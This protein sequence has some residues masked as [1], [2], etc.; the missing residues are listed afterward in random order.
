M[1][2]RALSGHVGSLQRAVVVALA[3][4]AMLWTTACL[5]E[6]DAPPPT[7][8]PT[9][10][11]D[12]TL[13]PIDIGGPSGVDHELAEFTGPM[14]DGTELT[15]R[16]DDPSVRFVDGEPAEIRRITDLAVDG[17][18]EQ[19][20]ATLEFWLGYAADP[21]FDRDSGDDPNGGDVSDDGTGQQA[22]LFGRAA[23]D[24][25]VFVGCP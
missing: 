1:P 7:A 19:L 23:Y 6:V 10:A 14:L 4:S 3:G 21:E 20:H 18:C 24:A 22:S 15:L 2:V 9:V 12:T 17:E 25:I 13:V 5:P 8:M 11:P 16:S